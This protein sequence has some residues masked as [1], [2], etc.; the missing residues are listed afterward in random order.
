MSLP[1]PEALAGASPGAVTAGVVGEAPAFT[2]SV[3]VVVVVVVG[4]ALGVAYWI[5]G[6]L[7]SKA[8][9]I[10]ES[11]PSMPRAQ[12]PTPASPNFSAS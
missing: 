11:V 7:P 9:T 3:V 1:A 5:A 4:G 12:T 6:G 10:A 2:G 8:V